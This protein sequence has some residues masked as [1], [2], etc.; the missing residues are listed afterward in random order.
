MIL[1]SLARRFSRQKKLGKAFGSHLFLQRKTWKNSRCS[2]WY[3]VPYASCDP[4]VKGDGS[5][6]EDRGSGRSLLNYPIGIPTATR[7]LSGTLVWAS[8]SCN[9]DLKASGFEIIK[10][11]YICVVLKL[12]VGDIS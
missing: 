11:L 12:L 10:D 2:G 1:L 9:V 8:E 4:R 3:S 5:F 6:A 7:L